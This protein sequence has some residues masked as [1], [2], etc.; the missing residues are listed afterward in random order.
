MTA[1]DIA[2]KFKLF[3]PTQGILSV[4]K[5][6]LHFV[7][8]LSSISRFSKE[9]IVLIKCI[10]FILCLVPAGI[11]LYETMTNTL[12]VNK[13]N[14]L[15]HFTGSWALY[16]LLI[17]LTITPLRRFMAY[18]SIVLHTSYGKRLSDWNWIIKLRRMLGLYVFFYATLHFSIYLILDQ[19]IDIEFIMEDII[20]RPF[21]AL[22]FICYL[23]LIPLVIT[24][25]N[26]MVRLL[27]KNWR[28]LHRLTYV[29]AIGA[30]IH[31]WWLT[32]VGIYTP[33]WTTVCLIILL[34][35]RVLA[36]YGLIFNRPKD[37]GMEEPERE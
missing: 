22:G 30:V 27:G 19:A 13:L 28:R 12:G 29:I 18:I 25:A 4:D 17:T 1:L 26:Y 3:N 37:I 23:L 7:N 11:L 33:I 8:I 36:Q 2:R 16:F 5:T 20:D 32:K 6:A 14:R 21:I 35:Y 9:H 24:S 34:A 31:Y 10:V 15:L